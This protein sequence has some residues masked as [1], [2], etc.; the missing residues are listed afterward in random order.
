[1]LPV[2]I[3]VMAL[4]LVLKSA[5]LMRV[6]AASSNTP[7]DSKPTVQA[8]APTAR[9]DTV[10]T[11]VSQ[12]TGVI[13]ARQAAAPA[14]PASKP[15][16]PPI[17]DSERALL[18]DLRARRAE[19]DAREA[20][21][22]SRETV[23]GAAE[24]RLAARIEELTSLQRKLETLEVARKDRDEANWRG[25]VKLYESMKPRDAATIFNDLDMPILLQVVDRMKEMKAAP[26]LAAMQPD[27]ARQLTAELAQMRL[28]ANAPQAA[29]G[30]DI[31]PKIGGNG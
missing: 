12:Q 15:P 3:G 28:R 23:L 22:A 18:V 1:L 31:S 30:K 10:N 6:A 5:G 19:L 25:L 27:R 24:K 17:S 20:A 8:Q 26:V 4:L 2:T 14:E 16:E 21:L 11:P 9:V 7:A 29:S 13:V